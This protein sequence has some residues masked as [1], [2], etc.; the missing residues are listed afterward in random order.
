MQIC[1]NLFIHLCFDGCLVH[2]L[3]SE[4]ILLLKNYK[5]YWVGDE[6]ILNDGIQIIYLTTVAYKNYL[7]LPLKYKYLWISSFH[8]DINSVYNLY[9]KILLYLIFKN[10]LLYKRLKRI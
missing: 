2:I 4:S 3:Y 8:I 9:L 10:P 5:H 1:D 7:T 6:K